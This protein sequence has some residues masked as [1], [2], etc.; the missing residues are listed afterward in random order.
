MKQVT[1]SLSKKN[2]RFAAF[3]EPYNL[4]SI[5]DTVYIKDSIYATEKIII[6][7]SLFSFELKHF[8]NY[9]Y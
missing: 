1:D 4:V 8:I 5:F 6:I 7:N 2:A 3:Q 9:D